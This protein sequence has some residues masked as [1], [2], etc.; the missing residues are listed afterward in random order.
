[1]ITFSNVKKEKKNQKMSNYTFTLLTF[2]TFFFISILCNRTNPLI[3][4]F[5]K[6]ENASEY[7]S[8][9]KY[10]IQATRDLI[11]YTDTKIINFYYNLNYKSAKIETLLKE[12]HRCSIAP[13]KTF[14]YQGGQEVM[15]GLNAV[16]PTLHVL[17]LS[18]TKSDVIQNALKH[19]KKFSANK[20]HQRY[21]LIFEEI[22]EDEKIWLR[23]IFELMW[24]KNILNVIVE[25]YL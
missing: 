14:T 19:L 18:K 20:K 5:F 11:C 1:M 17:F 6:R 15:D 21:L 24:S 25:F 9:P 2:F 3:S 13:I 8:F 22:V 16:D 10:A 23:E 7:S 12:I 4:N